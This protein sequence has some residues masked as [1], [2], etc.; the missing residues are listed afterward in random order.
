MDACA[1]T[2]M[3]WFW[4]PLHYRVSCT[5]PNKNIVFKITESSNFPNYL[6]FEIWYQQGN[7]DII[8]VQLCEVK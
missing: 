6:E 2:D 7:Q 8:A 5:Y 4:F 3:S 1:V